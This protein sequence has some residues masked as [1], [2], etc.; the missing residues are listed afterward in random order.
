M[1]VSKKV[2]KFGWGNGDSR[3]R[4]IHI[5]I[6]M[7]YV[8]VSRFKIN[9]FFKSTVTTFRMDKTCVPSLENWI[10]S[11]PNSGQFQLILRVCESSSWRLKFHGWPARS[12]YIARR[13]KK[14]HAAIDDRCENLPSDDGVSNESRARV[15]RVEQE[16]E[17]QRWGWKNVWRGS[18]SEITIQVDFSHARYRG[19]NACV[20]NA[21]STF[22]RARRQKMLC[23]LGFSLCPDSVNVWSFQPRNEKQA[24]PTKSFVNF[25][26]PCLFNSSKNETAFSLL[27]F[28]FF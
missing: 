19:R 22:I 10:E 17:R 9:I 20:I 27:L 6:H 7:W 18:H 4:I 24:R 21:F 1:K 5:H 12:I 15:E 11:F 8:L 16:F 13:C 3:L 14:N 25:S 2:T 23:T 26:R 28:F